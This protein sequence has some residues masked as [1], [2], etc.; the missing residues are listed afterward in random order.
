MTV[1]ESFQT[2]RLEGEKIAP[3]HFPDLQA[4]HRD[5][6]TMRE[7]GGV[8]SDAETSCYLSRNLDHWATHGFGVWMLRLKGGDRSIG[9]VVL[10][11]LCT[12]T[13]DD[14]EIG[15]AFLPAFWGRGFASEAAGFCLDVARTDLELRTLIGIATPANLASQRVL[16]KLGLC[17]ECDTI[18]EETPCLLFRSRW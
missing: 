13:I 15:F 4:L 3:E 18:V 8:R 9:R 12:E 17:Y 10:R 5:P 11:W 1:P 14:V 6:R 2:A 16:S 7:L